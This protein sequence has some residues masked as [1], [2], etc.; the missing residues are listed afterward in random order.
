MQ[1]DLHLV[2]QHV[3]VE[4]AEEILTLAKMVRR[5]FLQAVHAA[6][7]ALAT[8]LVKRVEQI[9]AVEVHQHRRRFAAG[10]G[11]VFL[12]GLGRAIQRIENR[13]GVIERQALVQQQ[14]QLL[15]KPLG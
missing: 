5:D 10:L 3:V 9:Q 1:D 8:G 4:V 15:P 6:G 7:V 14:H 2:F 13:Q 11:V 12:Q